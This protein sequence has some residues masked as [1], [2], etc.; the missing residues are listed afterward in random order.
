[1]AA[2]WE[3]FPGSGSDL[4]CMLALAD[5]A[6]D[7]GIAYPSIATLS[8]KVRLS[9][10]QTQKLLRRL[11]QDGWIA[12]IG[13][14]TGGNPNASR[15]YRLDL[16]RL[17]SV[18]GDTRELHDTGEL[19]DAEGCHGGRRGV[20]PVTPNPSLTVNNHKNA[21][22]VGALNVWDVAIPLLTDTG[23]SE[24][25]ARAFIGKLNRDYGQDATLAVIAQAV[26]KRPAEP[27]GWITKA[28]KTAATRQATTDIYTPA[29]K[30]AA[31]P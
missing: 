13:N 6:N 15:R 24:K 9:R 17:T 2:I 22:P 23:M 18:A 25:Q 28:L 10:R 3:H 5:F 29:T 19:D 20:S 14:A 21:A 26:H 31:T 7:T 4:L 11:E 27:C 16:S 8:R 30:G 12:V 1:M